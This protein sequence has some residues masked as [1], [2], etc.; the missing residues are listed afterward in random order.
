MYNKNIKNNDSKNS[1]MMEKFKNS[2]GISNIGKHKTVHEN[3]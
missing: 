3:R 1:K 2:N